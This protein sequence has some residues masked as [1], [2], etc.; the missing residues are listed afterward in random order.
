M[1]QSVIAP[2]CHLKEAC[3][4]QDMLSE[5][6]SFLQIGATSTN[7]A[8]AFLAACPSGR[9]AICE[10]DSK[11]FWTLRSVGRLQLVNMAVSDREGIAQLWRVHEKPCA[12]SLWLPKQHPNAKPESVHVTTPAK[13]LTMLGWT[14]ADVLALDCE[15]SEISIMPLLSPCVFPQ[16]WVEWH[17]AWGYYGPEVR[18]AMTAQMRARGYATYPFQGNTNYSLFYPESE[19]LR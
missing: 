4:R 12:N 10:P 3:F 2:L 17:V 13:L 8:L 14:S 15:S 18:R 6:P 11:T 7:D 5:N 1:S 19:P 9:A 16:V